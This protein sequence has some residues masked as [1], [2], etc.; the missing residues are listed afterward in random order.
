VVSSDE[1][2]PMPQTAQQAHV[3]QLIKEMA[4]AQVQRHGISRRKFL[5][6]NAGM[7]TAFL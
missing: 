3:E 5:S 6:T 4:D 1:Y 7:A 2:N